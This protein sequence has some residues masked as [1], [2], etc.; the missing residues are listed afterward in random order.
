MMAQPFI[1]AQIIATPGTGWGGMEQHTLA[2]CEALAN[3]GHTVHVLGHPDY[4]E[5]FAPPLIFHP[6]PM[7]LGR[8]NPWLRHRIRRTLRRIQPEVCHAQ[9]HKAA[10]LLAVSNPP[11][12]I[13]V[14]TIHGLKASHAGFSRLDAVIAVSQAVYGNVQHPRKY[15]VYNGITKVDLQPQEHLTA[16]TRATERPLVIAAG[17]LEPIK[18]FDRLLQAWARLEQPGHLVIAGQ[19]SQSASLHQL[20]DNLNLQDRVTLSGYREDLREWLGHADACVLSSDR[21]GFGYLIIEALQAGCPVLA[22][23][24]G[25]APELLSPSSVAG[26]TGTDAIYQLLRQHLPHLDHLRQIQADAMD[27][28]RT[29]FTITAMV[30]HTLACYQAIAEQVAIR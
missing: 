28:A 15:L 5:R 3:L 26:N 20:I 1:I 25:C 9:G 4:A 6:L 17:R 13:S 23:P 30:E 11:N 18:G 7:G 2:L 14:G 27:R 24:V 16:L 12:A 21:E 22:T 29:E 8:R 10:A 19:G